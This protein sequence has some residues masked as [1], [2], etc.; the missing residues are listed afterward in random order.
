MDV[1][2]NILQVMV[3]SLEETVPL[4]ETWLNNTESN[5]KH[6]N[7]VIDKI[8]LTDYNN[9]YQL[10]KCRNL[11][12]DW[13]YY[14]SSCFVSQIEI[15][16][17]DIA[18]LKGYS[19]RSNDETPLLGPLNVF[20][21][22][23]E[24]YRQLKEF[25]LICNNNPVT[26]LSTIVENI[27]ALILV[28]SNYPRNSIYPMASEWAP[29]Y[30]FQRQE[31]TTNKEPK[32]ET[33]QKVNLLQ[34]LVTELT[35]KMGELDT[36]LTSARFRNNEFITL[37]LGNIQT[38]LESIKD[39][40][41]ND[42]TYYELI[43]NSINEI[44]RTNTVPLQPRDRYDVMDRRE[45]ETR[46]ADMDR[47]FR[48]I[49]DTMTQYRK[50]LTD[51]QLISDDRSSRLEEVI[52]TSAQTISQLQAINTRISTL[53]ELQRDTASY[54]DLNDLQE[55]IAQNFASLTRTFQS[56]LV[57][58]RNDVSDIVQNLERDYT[59]PQD[60]SGMNSIDDNYYWDDT[61]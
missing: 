53:M 56:N 36:K 1:E 49:N 30:S 6:Y 25:N 8:Y 39:R 26:T 5:Y 45:M 35:E 22:H 21:K 27:N 16:S 51:T 46:L 24:R 38:D 34:C 3:K 59:V 48:D 43:L 32:H 50:A 11:L 18:R 7:N 58:L 33:D 42:D 20:A 9:A 4:Y 37:Q 52:N 17:N 15:V 57:S 2:N 23:L 55:L 12:R 41:K 19:I 14:F 40:L 61:Q 29:R 54:N 44:K 47:L 31:T 28:N 60:Q 13:Y 10:N